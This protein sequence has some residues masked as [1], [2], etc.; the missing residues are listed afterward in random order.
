MNGNQNVFNAHMCSKYPNG[1][2]SPKLSHVSKNHITIM[3]S[4]IHCVIL[5]LLIT[6]TNKGF[7]NMASMNSWKTS[8]KSNVYVGRGRKT[9]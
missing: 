8:D 9:T 6:N 3:Y 4:K 1:V 5:L 7:Q 2:F